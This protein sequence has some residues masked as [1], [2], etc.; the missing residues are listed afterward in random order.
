MKEMKRLI[1]GIVLAAMLLPL[2]GCLIVDRDR[3]GDG[4]GGYERHE[5]HEEHEERHEGG[6]Y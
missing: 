3:W 2:T 6:R 5:R 4:H 1:M